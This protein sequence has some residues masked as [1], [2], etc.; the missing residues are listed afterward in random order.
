MIRPGEMIVKG[1][2]EVENTAKTDFFPK[3]S[4]ET[5]PKVNLIHVKNKDIVIK[6][7]T[8]VKVLFTAMDLKN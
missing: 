4:Q 7:Q 3:I 5:K 1:I 6:V 8:R 2:K